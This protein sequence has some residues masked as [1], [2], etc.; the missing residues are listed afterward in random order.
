MGGKLLYVCLG[1]WMDQNARLNAESFARV[2]LLSALLKEEAADVLLTGWPYR[3]DCEV[4]IAR[5]MEIQLADLYNGPANIFL[6]ETARDT[7]GDAI[8]ARLWTERKSGYGLIHVVT[9]LYHAPRTEE[10][11]RFVFPKSVKIKVSGAGK[12]E[13]SDVP[14]EQKSIAAFRKTFSGVE[15]G[16]L[17]QIIQRLLS[18]H[19]YYN[20]EVH[21]ALEYDADKRHLVAR[22]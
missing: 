15:P 1:N 8:C 10:I 12:K 7:V 17:Q 3:S 19:P 22:S 16:D 21:P 20:G 4:S 6:D 5:A 13:R 9:S 2:Q 11:F 14:S 18:A